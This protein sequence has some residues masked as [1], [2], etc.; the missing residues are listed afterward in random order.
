V[1]AVI[2]CD[3]HPVQNLSVLQRVA[4]LGGDADAWAR[5]VIERG[6]GAV[7]ALLP[8]EGAFAFGD[9]P[10]LADV[11]IVP[12]LGNARRFGVEL[13]WPRIAA[14]EAACDALPAF[15][16]ARPENQPGAG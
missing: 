7:E 4:G 16:Y 1:A 8:D 5:D 14:A 2:A 13:R 15:R 6:L 3:T 10:T 9:A 11:L 12:Q